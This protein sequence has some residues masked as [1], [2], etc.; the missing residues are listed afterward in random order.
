VTQLPIPC[1]LVIITEIEQ[2]FTSELRAVVGDDG[3]WDLEAMHNVDKEEHR[4]L[5]FDSCDWS[6]LDPL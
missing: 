6:S 3:V 1:G 5:R 2:L 4:L